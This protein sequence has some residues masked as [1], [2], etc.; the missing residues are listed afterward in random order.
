M[1]SNIPLHV[2]AAIYA[3][4][5]SEEQKEGQTIDSQ[6]AELE[7]FAEEKSWTI[8]GV[9]KDEGWSGGLLARPELD[10]LRD[11][12]SKGKF[13]IVI[14]NDVDRLARD[15]AHL[16]IVKRN[17]E[18]CG[19]QIVFKKLPAEKSPTY[20]LMVN[21]LGSF[22]EFERELIIDR[23]RRGRRHKVEVRKQYLGSNPPYGYRYIPKDRASNKEG[24]LEVIP[25]EASVV[26]QMFEWVDQEGLSARLVIARLSSLKICPRKGG[27]EWGKSSVLRILRSETY[28]GVWHYNKHESC[29]PL[30]PTSKIKYRKTLKGSIRRRP[31][32]E[33]LPV[34]LPENLQIVDRGRW[35]RVQEQLTRNTAFS[36]RNAKHNYLLKG[37]IRCDGCGAHIV[38]DPCHGKFYYRCYKRCKQFPTIREEIL[39]DAV[40]QALAEAIRDPSLIVEQIKKLYARRAQNSKQTHS[41]M[42]EVNVALRQ[43]EE[44]EFRLI[45]AYRQGVLP[46]ALFGKEMERI[47]A[48]K[49]ALEKRKS[50]LTSQ[51]EALPLIEIK[52]SVAEYCKI[53]TQQMK[54][55]ASEARQRILRLLVTEIIYEG[56]QIRIRGVLPISNSASKENARA[57][58]LHSQEDFSNRRMA[59]TMM[60]SYN[61]NA[62]FPLGRIASLTNYSDGRN[63]VVEAKEIP[64]EITQTL[65]HTPTIYEQID[66]EYVRQRVRENPLITLKELADLSHQQFGAEPSITHMLRIQ[67]LAGISRIPGSRAKHVAG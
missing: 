38:G 24:F 56:T 4:V 63:S 61:H 11:E 30:N 41:E 46:M 60:H 25:E 36:P 14:I 18:H 23:T 34:S 45:E 52:R 3:R 21:I 5:S 10:R 58:L 62:D 26:K 27:K 64:F 13:D 35:Q 16:G 51:K 39:N 48:R 9:Y 44:E 32:T 6:I 40:W 37:L 66:L 47:N 55:F 57:K 19:V 12:A 8:I 15:V 54:N 53:L 2:R 42:V 22:A 59:S 67:Q 17:F 1:P 20:N 31:K 50:N 29:T 43:I 65:P 33:W 7:R 28:A 49:S